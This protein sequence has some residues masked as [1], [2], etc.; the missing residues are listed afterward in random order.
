MKLNNKGFSLVE[1]L[2]SISILSIV[3]IFMMHLFINIRNIYISNNEEFEYEI[4]KSRVIK[5]ISNDLNNN[6]LISYEKVNNKEVILHF[7]DG[8]KIIKITDNNIRYYDE[9]NE[10]INENLPKGAVVGNILIKG[11]DLINIH[12][13]LKNNN[14][15]YDINIYEVYY[16]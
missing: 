3:I 2:V 1:M 10:Y 11:K 15:N 7:E 5:N 4:L 6:K 13:P 9:N 16:E 8:S 12:I 14:K